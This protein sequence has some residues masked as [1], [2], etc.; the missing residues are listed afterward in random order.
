MDRTPR[1]FDPAHYLDSD[2]ARAVYLTDAFE[3]GDVAFIGKIGR[4]S[5]RERV[6]YTV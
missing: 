4:A 6:L 1:P 2:E 3:T 5:C